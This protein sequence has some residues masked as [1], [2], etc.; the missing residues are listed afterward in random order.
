MNVITPSNEDDLHLKISIIMAY[1][2]KALPTFLAV[3]IY[4][5][6]HHI[7]FAESLKLRHTNYC[8]LSTNVSKLPVLSTLVAEL[9]FESPE[10]FL[11]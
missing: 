8:T 11:L 1:V 7:L 5:F 3:H 10:V 6:A 2:G 9:T 4:P